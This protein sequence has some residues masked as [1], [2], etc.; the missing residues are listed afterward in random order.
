[1]LLPGNQA[2]KKVKKYLGFSIFSK[3][4]FFNEMNL[5]RLYFQ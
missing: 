3:D 4:L 5:L 1:M 2:K